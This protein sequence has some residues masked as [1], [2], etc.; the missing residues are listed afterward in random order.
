MRTSCLKPIIINQAW[1]IDFKIDLDN[2][3]RNKK[4][5]CYEAFDYGFVFLESDALR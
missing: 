5:S 4:A 2:V 1:W 3:I